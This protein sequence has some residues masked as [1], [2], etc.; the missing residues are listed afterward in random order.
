[1]ACTSYEILRIYQPIR[2]VESKGVMQRWDEK[3][4]DS[5][6]LKRLKVEGLEILSRIPV[7]RRLHIRDGEKWQKNSV[8]VKL[9]RGGIA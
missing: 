8:Q 3:N 2:A 7:I 6:P 1:M 5:G 9:K 4:V